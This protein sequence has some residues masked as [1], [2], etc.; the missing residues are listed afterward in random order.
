MFWNFFA[1][2]FFS[3][4]GGR[5][6][7]AFTEKSSINLHSLIIAEIYPFG[8]EYLRVPQAWNNDCRWNNDINNILVHVGVLLILASS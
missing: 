7:S 6:R 4:S 8:L 2:T 1:K 3:R 5:E